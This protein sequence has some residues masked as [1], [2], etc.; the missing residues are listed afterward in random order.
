MH[1]TYRN[2]TDSFLKQFVTFSFWIPSLAS[3]NLPETIVYPLAVFLS[4]G[5]NLIFAEL[6]ILRTRSGALQFRFH[7]G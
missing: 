6:W 1:G 7:E 5:L 2:Q 3:T 4:W